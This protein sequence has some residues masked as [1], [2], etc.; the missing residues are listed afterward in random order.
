MDTQAKSK[1]AFA[2]V[3]F[4]IEPISIRVVRIITVAP[5]GMSTPPILVSSMTIRHICTDGVV[6]RSNSLT[7][8]VF[9]RS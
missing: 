3:T 5:A 2:V 7:S 6:R 8:S 9:L 1:M 4:Y